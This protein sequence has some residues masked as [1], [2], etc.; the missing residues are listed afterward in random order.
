[1]SAHDAPTSVRAGLGLSGA[2][3]VAGLITVVLAYGQGYYASG[4]EVTADF[5]S[6]SQGLFT[7]GGSL[8]KLRGINV[9][10]VSGVELLPD[11]RAR[12]TLFLDEGIELPDTTSAAI[13]P[14]SVFGP[15]FV[16]LEPGEREGQGPFLSDGGQITRTQNQRELTDIL[17]S[18]TALFE[19]VDP[20]DL[21]VTIDAVAEGLAGL[22]PEIGRA[23]DASSALA[24]VAARHDDDLRRFLADAA[25][26]SDTFATSAGDLLATG[27]NA[28]TLLEALTDDP[29][30]FD[31]L[32]GVTI[33]LSETFADLLRDNEASI[34]VAVTSVS[35]FIAGVDAEADQLPEFLDMVGT[36]FGRFSDVIRFDGPAG[37]KMAALRGFV[38]LDLCLVYGVCVGGA[39]VDDAA[40]LQAADDADP[41]TGP[42]VDA[43]DLL[44][45][46]RP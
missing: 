1:M 26:L 41:P 11:G 21:V 22:G 25:L 30:R 43:V 15:K 23:I 36:F 45:G 19:A 37:T 44:T 5:P 17:A 20:L 34:D 24:E 13:E 18:T 46:A 16:R 12:V 39:S 33:D 8:V 29:E 32:L 35:A 2:L 6:S 28:T 7:D 38:A 42:L 27:R 40:V 3:L 10:T 9:G 31:E 4:Y 14:L